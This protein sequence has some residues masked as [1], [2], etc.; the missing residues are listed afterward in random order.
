MEL[1]GSRTLPAPVQRVWTALNDPETL[2]A[3]MPGC[4]SIE[5]DGDNAYR[6]A[7][8]AKIGPVSARF[9][10]K[11]QVVDIDAPRAYTIRFEGS[12]GPAGFVNGEARVTLTPEGVGATTL[13]YAAKAQI[14]GKLAQVG[15]RLVDAAAQKLTEDFFTRFVA[16]VCPPAETTLEHTPVRGQGWIKVALIVAVIVVALVFLYIRGR[17]S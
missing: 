1:T 6:A 3:S 17:S 9:T 7:L 10:G 4:E 16:A 14:G 15:S 13:T 11:M 12:G 2:K 8:V 5:P